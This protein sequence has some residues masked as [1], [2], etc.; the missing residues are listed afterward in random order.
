MVAPPRISLRP[1]RTTGRQAPVQ[2]ELSLQRAHQ[3]FV[4]RFAAGR[5]RTAMTQ[6]QTMA[7]DP[8]SGLSWYDAAWLTRYLVRQLHEDLTHPATTEESPPNP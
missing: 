1:R 8:N 2:W 3:C 5:E 6:V 7:E 4:F